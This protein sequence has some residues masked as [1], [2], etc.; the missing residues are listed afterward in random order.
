MKCA[1]IIL[2]KKR[3]IYCRVLL[4]I[5]SGF[6]FFIKISLDIRLKLFKRFSKDLSV[7]FP[8]GWLDFGAVP[9]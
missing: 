6:I 8:E 7:G 1:L 2:E 5:C 4:F 3:K 9:F